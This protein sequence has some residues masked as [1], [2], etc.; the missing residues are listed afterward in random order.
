MSLIPAKWD[1]T[2]IAHQ[3]PEHVHRP[4]DVQQDPHHAQ[5]VELPRDGEVWLILAQDLARRAGRVLRDAEVVVSRA[6]GMGTGWEVGAGPVSSGVAG[7]LPGHV[8]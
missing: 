8:V 5:D 4:E 1:W 3:V 6:L 7:T 2:Y